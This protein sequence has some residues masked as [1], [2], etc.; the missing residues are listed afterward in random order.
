MHLHFDRRLPSPVTYLQMYKTEWAI[1]FHH[2][3]SNNILASRWGWEEITM[4]DPNSRS[5]KSGRATKVMI[6]DL[7]ECAYKGEGI[8]AC[9]SGDPHYVQNL[10]N[11]LAL[12]LDAKDILLAR[13]KQA[14]ERFEGIG[15]AKAET[16]LE[17]LD[18]NLPFYECPDDLVIYDD[19]MGHCIT[20]GDIRFAHTTLA[21]L[22]AALPPK[23]P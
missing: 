15:S 1:L 5:L 18:Y 6:D 9:L 3:S 13:A 8:G 7:K 4:P 11:A 20:V 12:A 14:L 16:A 22:K 21:S 10:L 2:R 23:E 17:L 19:K